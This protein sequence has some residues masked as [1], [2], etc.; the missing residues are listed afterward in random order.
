[1]IEQLIRLEFRLTALKLKGLAEMHEEG[2][3]E[4]YEATEITLEE[5]MSKLVRISKL[6]TMLDETVKKSYEMPLVSVLQGLNMFKEGLKEY[7]D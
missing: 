5:Y 6:K 1:M 3:K 7:E 2:F 4:A